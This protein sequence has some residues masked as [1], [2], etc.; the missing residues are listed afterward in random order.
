MYFKFAQCEKFVT[1]FVGYIGKQSV[2]IEIGNDKKSFS[3]DS[4]ELH[5]IYRRCSN[6]ISKSLV[7]NELNVFTES[8]YSSWLKIFRVRITSNIFHEGQGCGHSL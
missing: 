8:K 1:Q 7:T 4:G 2:L 6:T 3:N 5:R